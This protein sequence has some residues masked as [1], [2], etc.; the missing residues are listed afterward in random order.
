[1]QPTD[2]KQFLSTSIQVRDLMRKMAKM[3]LWERIKMVSRPGA[4]RCLDARL[5]YAEEEGDTGHRK[6]PRSAPESTAGEQ[7]KKR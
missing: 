7:E 4:V 2:V 1:M 5:E 6:S 3:S